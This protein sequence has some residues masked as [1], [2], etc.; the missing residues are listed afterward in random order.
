MPASE[1]SRQH[2]EL[3]ATIDRPLDEAMKKKP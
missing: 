1:Y 2:D 3:T